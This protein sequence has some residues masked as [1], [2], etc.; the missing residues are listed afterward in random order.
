MQVLDVL[1]K[2]NMPQ[3]FSAVGTSKSLSLNFDI[4]IPHYY[5]ILVF[6]VFPAEKMMTKFFKKKS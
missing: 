2:L 3:K 1:V 6:R 5:K 4:E